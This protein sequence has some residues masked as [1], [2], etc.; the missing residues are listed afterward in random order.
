MNP[1]EFIKEIAGPARRPL[2]IIE[3]GEPS[4]LGR[5]LDAAREA[6]LPDFRDFNFQ[7]LDLQAGEAPRL[8]GEAATMPFFAAPRVLAVKNPP[9]SGEDWNAL[10]AY[11][12][13][14]N[15]ESTVVLV[16]DKPD[17]RLK[18][19]KKAKSLGLNVDCAPP[20][21]AA[22]A[23]WLADEFARR[24]VSLTGQAARLIIERAG[25]EVQALLGEAEK[26]SLY[27]GEGGR[28]TPEMVKN[29]VSLAPGGN[30]FELGEAL[31]R[32][33]A[34]R[35]LAT[36]LE[37]LATEPHLPV[38]AMMVRHFR[39][40]LQVK[41]LQALYGTA[42]LSPEQ[43]KPLGLHP[44]VLEKTSPQAERWPWK[45]VA[46]ALLAT[47]EAHGSSSGFPL[48][49]EKFMSA[50]TTCDEELMREAIK[51]AKLA[52]EEDEVPAGAVVSDASGR[53]LGRGHNQVVAPTPRSWPCAR[54]PAP[55]AITASPARSSTAPWSPAPCVSWPPST[56]GSPASSLARPNPNGA[57]PVPCATFLPSPD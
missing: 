56:P 43:A 2:Y 28:L 13:D 48:K 8:L 16:V 17:S 12:D 34:S 57:P 33:D 53:I 55:S 37:L 6:A 27:V 47:E 42:R 35:G 54:P 49:R 30:V 18:F 21:G 39:L 22:L 25:S 38:L 26:L 24:G 20:R 52:R 3:G 14:P 36:L 1:E 15:T 44:Y 51:E 11:L 40:I 19:F 32:Q 7:L 23:K 4:A 31:G 41:T 10:A 45:A 5:C 50:F 9:F 29:M 46:A